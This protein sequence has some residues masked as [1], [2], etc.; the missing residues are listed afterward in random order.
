MIPSYLLNSLE[1]YTHLRKIRLNSCC[2][3][4]IFN[5]KSKVYL[6][7]FSNTL[8]LLTW[9]LTIDIVLY[10]LT[11]DIVLYTVIALRKL[12]NKTKMLKILSE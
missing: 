4:I 10:T 3:L 2:L 11:I 7:I 8:L 6:F 12:S 9:K 5:W 1:N